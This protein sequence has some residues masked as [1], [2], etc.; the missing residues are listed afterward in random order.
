MSATTCDVIIAGAGIVGAAC[1]LALSRRGHKCAIVDPGPVA[2]GATGAGMGHICVM[3]DSE[4]Q[5]ELS[6]LSRRLWDD[7][8]PELPPTAERSVCGTLWVAAD[9]EEM[10]A[11]RRKGA[12]LNAH[13]VTADLLD[14]RLLAAAEPNLRPGLF[15]G[16]MLPGDSIVYPPTI[17][18]WMLD[19]AVENGSRLFI[20]R[21]I[22]RLGGG[23]ADLDDGTRLEAAFSINAAGIWAPRLTP[24]LPVR[25]RKGHLVITD[26]YPGFCRAEIVELGYIKNAHGHSPESVAFNIQPRPTGQLLIGSSRQYDREDPAVEP[27]MLHRMLARAV[28]FMPGLAGLKTIRAWTG[29]RAATPDSLP[30]IGTHPT[31]SRLLLATGHEGLGLTT[32]TG[33]A[34]LIESIVC[35][36]APPIPPL[37]YS[38]SRFAELAVA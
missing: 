7:L 15:G 17:V 25:P 20:G 32:A 9:E 31:D 13:N 10:L 12:Y 16:L 8:A 4:P 2:G 23:Y 14:A 37:P 24:T 22:A 38:P 35:R 5:L 18:R 3:D 1:A 33:T 29:F 21:S 19:R 36:T 30:I 27:H 26:R 6:R 34:A 11:A 28:E